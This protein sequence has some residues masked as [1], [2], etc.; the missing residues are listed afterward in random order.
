VRA[1]LTGLFAGLGVLLAAQPAAAQ[2]RRTFATI[3]SLRHIQSVIP[4]SGP[5]GTRVTIYTENLP[6]QAKVHIGVG[7]LDLG[8]EALA[9]AFQGTY[10]EVSA[11]VDVPEF[12]TWDKP[13]VLIV[14][15]GI[16]SPIGI[17]DPFH[18]TNEDGR[19]LRAGTVTDE[20]TVC[21][22]MRSDEGYLYALIGDI[23][24]VRVGEY[25][26]VE[27]VFEEISHCT[28][29]DALRVVKVAA[30]R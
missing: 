14:F 20:G 22:T 21:P 25:L 11:A 12:G 10:G 4:R 17:S 27:A 15:N 24:D 29:G 5:P 18:V 13:M 30:R 1:A 19:V 2:D 6:P 28:E 23:E 16:F 7:K 9:E 26:E 3:D 8:W